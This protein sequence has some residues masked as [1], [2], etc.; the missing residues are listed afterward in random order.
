M[1]VMTYVRCLYLF[2]YVWKEEAHSYT[3]VPIRRILRGSVFKFTGGD[4]HTIN[5]N[6][7]LSYSLT[8]MF[9]KRMIRLFGLY[10]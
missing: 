5:D 8:T 6:N 9:D 1:I 7:M 3:M 10:C 4:N 2:S